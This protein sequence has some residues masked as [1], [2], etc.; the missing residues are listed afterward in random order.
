MSA[1]GGA[2]RPGRAGA[3]PAA[4]TGGRPPGD[5]APREHQRQLTPNRLAAQLSNLRPEACCFEFRDG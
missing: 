4:H 1:H 5:A 3:T 2:G